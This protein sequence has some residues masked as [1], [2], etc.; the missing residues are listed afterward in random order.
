MCTPFVLT[1]EGVLSKG[2]DIS[3]PVISMGQGKNEQRELPVADGFVLSIVSWSG[4]KG[5][6]WNCN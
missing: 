5:K 3:T 1:D 6:T 2:S 4:L